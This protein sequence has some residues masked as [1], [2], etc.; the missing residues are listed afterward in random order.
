[1]TTIQELQNKAAELFAELDMTQDFLREEIISSEISE[2]N[3][4]LKV[5]DTLG[6]NADV[7]V[8]ASDVV[9]LEP[10]VEVH[11]G[12]GRKT[13]SKTSF[14]VKLAPES[15]LT[16]RVADPCGQCEECWTNGTPEWCT[17][18]V[19]VTA[20]YYKQIHDT[21]RIWGDPTNGFYLRVI[22]S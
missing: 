22:K 17:S 20:Y 21:R 2:I 8:A 7:P 5:F 13:Y 6:V 19:M 16:D 11:H 14:L 1:M 4:T 10:T 3:R 9:A 18:Q 12:D 15:V